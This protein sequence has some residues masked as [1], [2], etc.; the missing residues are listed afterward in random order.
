MSKLFI[1]VGLPGCGKT[2]FGERFFEQHRRISTDDIRESLSGDASDQSKNGEVFAR[3]H[4]HIEI[5][6]KTNPEGFYADATNLDKRARQELIAIAD[7][8]SAE[9]H[10]ILFDNANQAVVRN[11]NRERVVPDHVMLRFADKFDKARWDVYDEG[12]DSITVISKF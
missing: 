6:L 11:V 4:R 2:T 12:Y 5:G 8:V 7:S 3:F 1:P 9:I 10:V